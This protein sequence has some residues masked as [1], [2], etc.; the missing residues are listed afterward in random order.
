MRKG[1]D[2]ALSD[3]EEKF[4]R[5]LGERDNKSVMQELR[6]LLYNAIDDQ[7]TLY[8]EEFVNE[9]TNEDM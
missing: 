1:L 5:W 6:T 3:N 9:C 4:I 8:W 7:K 2:I